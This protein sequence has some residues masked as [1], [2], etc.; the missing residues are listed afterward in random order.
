ME[1]RKIQDSRRDVNI[2]IAAERFRPPSSEMG[3]RRVLNFREDWVLYRVGSF[4]LLADNEIII[5][6]CKKI[7]LFNY[8][9]CNS[10]TKVKTCS[11]CFETVDEKIF[12]INKMFYKMF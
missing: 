10:C 12:I 9:Y 8:C 4:A 3:A 6:F 7:G 5:H 2:E 1:K 11:H